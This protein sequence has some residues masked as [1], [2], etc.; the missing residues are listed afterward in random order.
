M[1]VGILFTNEGKLDCQTCDETLRKERGHDTTGIVPFWIDGKA[2]YRCPLTLITPISWDLIKAYNLY[3]K[4]F[5]PNGK[6]WIEESQKFIEAMQIVENEF[7][8][9]KNKDTKKVKRNATSKP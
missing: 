4:G 1:A 6:G 7:I 8:R 3:E 9:W 2:I 5:L